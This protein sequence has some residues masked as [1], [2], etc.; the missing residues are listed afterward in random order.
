M[1]IGNF[2]WPDDTDWTGNQITSC[3]VLASLLDLPLLKATQNVVPGHVTAG[4]NIEPL[5]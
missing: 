3:C 5:R 2:S 4:D 1:P